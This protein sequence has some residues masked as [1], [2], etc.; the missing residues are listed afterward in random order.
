MLAAY[1]AAGDGLSLDEYLGTRVFGAAELDVA[2]P[3]AAD[4][5]GYA[6]FL[7]RYRAGLAV[8]RAATA[9]L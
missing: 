1:R 5:A 9:A 6:A 3:D 2:E 4:V 8:E 7:D